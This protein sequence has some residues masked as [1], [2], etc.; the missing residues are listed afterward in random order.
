[1]KNSSEVLRKAFDKGGVKAMA[2]IKSLCVN[3]SSCNILI[4]SL[5]DKRLRK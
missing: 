4:V 3:S 1:M 5:K 2:Y